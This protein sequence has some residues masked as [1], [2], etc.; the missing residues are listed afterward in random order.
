MKP[1]NPCRQD[2]CDG[3]LFIDA[4]SVEGEEPGAIPEACCSYIETDY[5]GDAHN[6][7]AMGCH[8]VAMERIL[9]LCDNAPADPTPDCL[10]PEDECGGA[11]CLDGCK[12]PCALFDDTNDTFKECSACATSGLAQDDGSIYQCHP[13]ALG[14][15]TMRCC[16]MA[17]E[18][19]AA[20][21]Q[22][23][24]MCNTLESYNCLFVQ[25]DECQDI[26]YNQKV[27]ASPTGCCENAAASSLTDDVPEI[28]CSGDFAP[29]GSEQTFFDNK[30]CADLLAERAEE[31]AS[32]VSDQSEEERRL[33]AAYATEGCGGG[34]EDQVDTKKF[35]CTHTSG[36]AG[37]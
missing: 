31:A 18:C 10:L 19:Q 1:S 11:Q 28:L 21:V 36:R 25:H 5:C 23:D 17:P 35:P 7:N 22:N 13:D 20:D 24:E 34:N 2:V 9:A 30:V 16:G 14:Y 8:P 26:V 6:A 32:D 37:P 33:T 27:K 12:Q 4:S 15:Q 29:A 3:A